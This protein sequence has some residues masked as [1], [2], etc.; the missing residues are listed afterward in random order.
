MNLAIPAVPTHSEYNER[1]SRKRDV[2][3][4]L[5]NALH[6]RCPNCRHGKVFKGWPNRVLPKCPSCGLSYFRESGYYLGGMII[7]YI[8]T[9]FIV[10][11]LYLVSLMIPAAANFSENF[12]YAF[13]AILAISLTLVLT[14]PAYSLWLALDF[15]IDPW[16][17]DQPDERLRPG[18]N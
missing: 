10:V 11:A 13:W 18:S 17:P 1:M 8:L 9:A 3:G 14:R 2:G 7:T 15:L 12:T 16:T 4:V 6:C 5:L